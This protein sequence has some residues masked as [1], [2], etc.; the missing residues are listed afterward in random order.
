MRVAQLA[1]RVARV[2]V[3]EQRADVPA[4]AAVDRV[5]GPEDVDLFGQAHKQGLAPRPAPCQPFFGGVIQRSG[6][7]PRGHA[8][9]KR[10][11]QPIA[12]RRNETAQPVRGGAGRLLGAE[13]MPTGQER[14]EVGDGTRFDA[15]ARGRPLEAEQRLQIL[16]VAKVFRVRTGNESALRQGAVLHELGEN[17]GR[18]VERQQL[19]KF[20]GGA[21]AVELQHLRRLRERRLVELGLRMDEVGAGAVLATTQ[22]ARNRH[23][24]KPLAERHRHPLA[25]PLAEFEFALRPIARAR[26]LRARLEIGNHRGGNGRAQPRVEDRLPDEVVRQRRRVSS[27]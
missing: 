19:D 7:S 4:S 10:L 12:H 6:R 11:V 9:R 13:S 18:V 1:E 15:R 5:V 20:P 23:V 8:R 14:C 3:L 16:R 27:R 22:A 17:A 24:R 25:H 26:A 21:R 2:R